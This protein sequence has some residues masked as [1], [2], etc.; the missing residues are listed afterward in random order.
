MLTIRFVVFKSESARDKVIDA[1]LAWSRKLQADKYREQKHG[2][3]EKT[4]N[5]R[6]RIYNRPVVYTTRWDSL[7][8]LMG[9]EGTLHFDSLRPIPPSHG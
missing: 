7:P 1:D 6:W 9:L 3:P 2:F 4:I 8:C 5:N